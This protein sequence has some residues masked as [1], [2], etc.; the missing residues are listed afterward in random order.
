[1]SALPTC[2]PFIENHMIGIIFGDYCD[3]LPFDYGYD[4]KSNSDY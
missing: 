4:H 2:S 1:V 3:G